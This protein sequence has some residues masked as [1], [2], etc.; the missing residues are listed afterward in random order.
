MSS[1][2]RQ[3]IS[4][5]GRR[6]AFG[7]ALVVV[8]SLGTFALA[9][10]SPFDPLDSYLGNSGDGYT[11]AQRADLR[12]TLGLDQGWFSAWVHWVSHTAGG[13]L[14]FSRAYHQPVTD[15][16]GDRFGWTVLLGISGAVVA[17]IVGAALGI[18]AGLRAGGIADRL[19]TVFASVLQAVP[20]FI[21]ALGSVLVFS[22]TLRLFPASGLTDPGGAIT[23]ESTLRHLIL[24]ALVLGISQTP[25]LALGLRQAIVSAVSSDAIRGAY[26]RGL[27]R[28]VIELRHIVPMGLAPFFALVGARLPELIIGAAVVETVFSWPGL[29]EATINAVRAQDFPLLAVVTVLTVAVVVVGNLAADLGAAIVD[30]RIEADG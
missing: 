18:V 27:P 21:V 2:A 8:V 20:P 30:P 9:G 22:V 10:A 23:A 29:G 5:S 7:V 1:R 3:L 24:P 19:V 15:V 25:W 14:G 28:R 4:M 26:A 11:E 6:A 17:V 12:R 16:L 13:D